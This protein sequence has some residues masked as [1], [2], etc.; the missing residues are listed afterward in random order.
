LFFC[1]YRY[2]KNKEA[3]GWPDDGE[4]VG[5]G[6][7]CISGA[8]GPSGSNGGASEAKQVDDLVLERLVFSIFLCCWVEIY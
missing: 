2:G 1:F 5:N 3:F 6:S 7:A 8:V 4:D